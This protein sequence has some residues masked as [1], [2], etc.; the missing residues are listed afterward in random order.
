MTVGDLTG[1]DLDRAEVNLAATGGAGDGADDSVIVN[2]SAGADR[3]KVVT[4]GP[5]VDVNGLRTQTRIAGAEATDHL[6]VNTVDGRDRV[7]VDGDV[8]GRID[9]GVD[10]GNGQL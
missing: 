2:G 9:I 1:T 8:F 4:D 7:T 6:Q 3:V 5:L 10:L